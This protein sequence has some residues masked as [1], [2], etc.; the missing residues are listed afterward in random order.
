MPT[1]TRRNSTSRKKSVEQNG[2]NPTQMHLLKMFEFANSKKML[3]ELKKVLDKFYEDQINKEMDEL[4]ESGKMTDEKFD[5]ILNSHLR[6][7]Y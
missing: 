2:L 6:T 5:K 3:S 4:W 1:A 7:S